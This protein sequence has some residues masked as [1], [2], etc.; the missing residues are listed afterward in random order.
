MKIAALILCASCSACGGAAATHHDHTTDNSLGFYCTTSE[1]GV[2]LCNRTLSG[3]AQ[4]A[5]GQRRKGVEMTDCAP[6]ERAACFTG[7]ERLQDLSVEYCA[8]S[9]RDCQGLYEATTSRGKD[10]EVSQCEERR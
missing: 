9:F 6:Y 3:C 5:D 8:L 10:V 4:F 1:N 7:Y 2:G